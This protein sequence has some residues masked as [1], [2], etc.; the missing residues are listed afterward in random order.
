MKPSRDR[1]APGAWLGV[2]GGGQLGRMFCMAAQ[3]L[4]FRV[5]VLDPAEDSPAAT[6]ADRHIQAD[7]L[8]AGGL[9][10]MA[11][12]CVAVTTEFEN[13]PAEA[14]EYLEQ[15]CIVCPSAT[16]VAIAQDRNAEKAF[17]ASCEIEVGPHRAV[18]SVADVDALPAELFPGILKTARLGYDGKGQRHVADH[19]EAREAFEAFGGVECVLEKRLDLR[20][21]ISV[22]V[23]RTAD[24]ETA[25]YPVA[26]NIHRNGILAISSVPARV[27][28]ELALRATDATVRIAHALDYAGVLCVEYFILVDGSLVANEIAPRPHNSGHYTLDACV[29]SQFEQQARVLAGWPL[30]GTQQHQPAV[31]LNILGDAWFRGEEGA[32]PAE[33]D[34]FKVVSH[35][36]ARLHLY[37]KRV[38]RPGRKMGH[39]TVLGDSLE[40]ALGLVQRIEADLGLG[41]A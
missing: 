30:A 27:D 1:L 22:V 34:W 39:V 38:P 23:A 41:P 26:E 11:T 9:E 17:I 15:H 25:A 29:S 40:Q 31:M 4:G 19:D 35:P 16:A 12:R 21:E 6:V 36:R 20:A 7:Y 10:E 5:C 28:P 18:R 33:P 24:G 3:S 37:G 32:G 2:L 13:V 8:S 14:L